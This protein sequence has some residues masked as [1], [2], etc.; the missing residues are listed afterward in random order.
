MRWIQ[1]LA[2]LAMV[3]AG[4]VWIVQGA[5]ALHGSF[6]T[7][8]RTWLWTGIAMAAIGLALCVRGARSGRGRHRSGSAG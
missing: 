6:M 8:S 1:L 2:G 3:I 4:T 7:G 5:G